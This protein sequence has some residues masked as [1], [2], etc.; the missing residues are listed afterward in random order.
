MA[1]KTQIINGIAWVGQATASGE[2]GRMQNA[3]KIFMSITLSPGHPIR[4]LNIRK[5]QLRTALRVCLL[6]SGLPLFLGA[7]DRRNAAPAAPMTPPAPYVDRPVGRPDEVRLLAF[8]DWGMLTT[9][10][11]RDRLTVANAMSHYLA[12]NPADA[13]LLLGDNFYIRLK[14]A[15][16]P[17]IQELFEKTYDVAHFNFPFYA[18]L[19]NHDYSTGNAALEYIY[20]RRHPETRWHFPARWYRLDFPTAANPLATILMLDSNRQS[21]SDADWH[22]ELAWI[23]QELSKPRGQWTICCGHHTMFSNGAHSDNGVLQTD[24]GSL[25]QQQHVDFYVCGHDHTLQHLEIPNWSTSFVISGGG[26]G[27]RRPMLRDDRGPF[28]AAQTGF[29]YIRLTPEMADVRI[30]DS[31]ENLLHEFTRDAHGSV[32]ILANTASEKAT[33]FKLRVIQGIDSATSRPTT[34][35]ANGGR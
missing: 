35:P 24:W 21:L 26:A 32:K 18:A 31:K 34:E 17:L 30:L 33:K 28:S 25:F 29:T 3:G 8:G 1:H 11:N 6:L 15:D 13:A 27:K 23:K 16:D 14:D 2:I 10:S 19:G 9:R 4:Y 22:E 5:D 7:C 20:P 12:Q